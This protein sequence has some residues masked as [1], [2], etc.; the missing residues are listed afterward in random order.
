[1][2]V[3]MLTDIESSTK[4]WESHSEAMKAALRRHDTILERSVSDHGGTV[5]KNTGDGI[6][7]VFDKGDP[8]GCA[9]DIQRSLQAENWQQIDE[10]RVRMAIHAG[11]A[12]EREGDYFGPEV[13]RTARLLDTGWGGQILLSSSALESCGIPD[14]AR[15]EDL[16]IHMLKDLEAPIRIFGL[17]HPDLELTVFPPLRTLSSRPN[18]LPEQLTP[19][20]GRKRE[21]AE[22]VELMSSPSCRLLT[23]TGIGGIGKTRLALQLGSE[24]LNDFE[25]GVFFVPL[26][27]VSDTGQVVPAIAESLKL[28]FSGREKATTELIDYL[29]GKSLLLLLDNFEHVLDAAGV[30][31][32]VLSSAPGVSIVATSRIRL[33]VSAEHAYELEG[34]EFPPPVSGTPLSEYSSIELFLHSLRRHSPFTQTSESDLEQIL[35]ICRLVSGVPLGIELA[36]AWVRVLS[37]GEILSEIGEGLELLSSET[38]DFPDRH[39]S[40]RTVFEYSWELLDESDRK[41]FGDV[42][43]FR[44]GFTR[45]AAA[46]ICGTSLS[47]LRSLIDKSLLHRR[48]DGRYEVHELLRQYAREK[49][50]QDPDRS[51]RVDTAHRNYYCGLLHDY[52]DLVHGR[53]AP[54]VYESVA[55]ELGNITRAWNSAVESGDADLLERAGPTLSA[56]LASRGFLAE[57]EDLFARAAESL[58]SIDERIWALMRAE[59]AGYLARLTRYDEAS[60]IFRESLEVFKRYGDRR[61]IINC[62]YGLGGSHMRMGRLKQARETLSECLE[63]ARGMGD[64]R[65]VARALLGLGDV[66][67]HLFNTERSIELCKESSEL[68]GRLGDSYGQYANSVVIS[69]TSAQAGDSAKAAE[70]ADMAIKHA[71]KAGDRSAIALSCSCAADAHILEGNMTAALEYA[72]RSTEIYTDQGSRWGLQISL[73]CMAKARMR[74]G[75]AREAEEAL[76]EGIKVT[77]EIGATHNSAETYLMA[78]DLWNHLGKPE[79]AVDYYRKGIRT[80]DSLGMTY[81]VVRGHL[82]LAST[83]TELDRLD[84]GES[85]LIKAL[86]LGLEMEDG[87]L[88]EKALQ[89]YTELFAKRGDHES[90]AKIASCLEASSGRVRID[91]IRELA[92]DLLG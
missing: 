28:S 72:E 82:G 18:N 41:T 2:P 16:D 36:A 12:Q 55:A 87:K 32:D 10:L 90:E 51:E 69:N 45:E 47:N 44:G 53:D 70:Y 14:K 92:K 78:G 67:N 89:S 64:D 75:L 40:M 81:W 49:A 60:E 27:G 79:M 43:V 56:F 34:L 15:I 3:F 66:E 88:L 7:A 5:I 65:L 91:R 21:M 76:L 54:A 48:P 37:L 85:S 57:G 71:Q 35:G 61:G 9:L 63:M 8:L 73:L 46:E 25:D 22:L 13:N 26:A 17:T 31:S 1:M 68:F 20:V 74:L 58:K 84:Q 11:S 23:I 38:R 52:R 30:V 4:L 59:R 62:L 83:A 39:R 6:F 33:N 50:D 77:D 19:F 86:Q 24:L 42:A 29:R 80:A